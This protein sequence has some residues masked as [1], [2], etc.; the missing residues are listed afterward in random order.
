ML[1][2]PG[3]YIPNKNLLCNGQGLQDALERYFPIIDL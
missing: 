1:K 2:D 3:I